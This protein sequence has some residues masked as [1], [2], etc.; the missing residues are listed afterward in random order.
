MGLGRLKEGNG[1]DTT[2]LYCLYAWICQRM[3]MFR[4]RKISEEVKIPGV[5][6]TTTSQLLHFRLIPTLS[7][8]V[9]SSCSA[10]SH[11]DPLPDGMAAGEV[12]KA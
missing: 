5:L 2:I 7:S 1:E 10:R 6:Y 4:K 9:C 11:P 8:N 3:N 12:S